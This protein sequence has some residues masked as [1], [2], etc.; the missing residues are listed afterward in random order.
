M[1]REEF[2]KAKHP[3]PILCPNCEHQLICKL[4]PRWSCLDFVKGEPIQ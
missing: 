4:A 1:N 2:A 3:S